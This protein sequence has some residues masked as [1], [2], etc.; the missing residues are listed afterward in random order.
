MKVLVRIRYSQ[1]LRFVPAV[2]WWKAA[3]ALAKVSWTRSSASVGLRVIRSA[4][5]YSWSRCTSASR[6]NRR[7]RSASP[8]ASGARWVSS[9]ITAEP[10]PTGTP[11]PARPARLVVVSSSTHVTSGVNTTGG[12]THSRSPRGD[13]AS[14][15]A[16]RPHGPA[17]RV[18]EPDAVA[19]TPGA[20]TLRRPRGASAARPACSRATAPGP[21]PATCRTLV[22]RRPTDAASQDRPTPAG[23]LVRARRPRR[24][25]AT[26]PRTPW[27][28]AVRPT[29]SPPRSASA[30]LTENQLKTAV[31]VH[32]ALTVAAGRVDGHGRRAP[33]RSRP[34]PRRADAPA[35]PRRPA[36]HLRPGLR[37]RSRTERFVRRLGALGAALLAGVDT[38]GKPG[39]VVADRARP[40]QARRDQGRQ[41]DHGCAR[42]PVA[43]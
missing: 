16:V 1:A 32:G 36:L 25:S 13:A 3:N 17:I 40:R 43:R 24:R 22:V 4:A 27:R 10:S 9:V 23:H 37:A 33:R 34:V 31:R 26:L 2:Y 8:S 41:G 19:V 29:R 42:G 5:E 12:R 18:R 6:S 20:S 11:A 7:D 15:G 35:R 21:V 38:E 30:P 14:R 39:H 28:R